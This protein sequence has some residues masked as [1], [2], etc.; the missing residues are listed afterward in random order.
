MLRVGDPRRSH[1]Y[2]NYI[3]ILPI[4]LFLARRIATLSQPQSMFRF[5]RFRSRSPHKS[6]T[7]NKVIGFRDMLKKAVWVCGIVK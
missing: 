1:F 5:G 3:E 2:K 4:R 6:N 7:V